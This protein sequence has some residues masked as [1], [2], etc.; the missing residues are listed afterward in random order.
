MNNNTTD[1]GVVGEMFK[2]HN[3]RYDYSKKVIAYCNHSGKPIREG[4]DYLETQDG[5]ILRDDKHVLIEY[6]NLHR[7][8]QYSGET[9]E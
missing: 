7:V 6:F 8:T 4:E 5:V 9:D 2:S 3:P 1:F